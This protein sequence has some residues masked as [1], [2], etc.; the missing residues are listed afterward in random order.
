MRIA[1]L[2]ANFATAGKVLV[3][4]L[5][6]AWVN[7][8][9]LVA[10]LVSDLVAKLLTNLVGDGRTTQVDAGFVAAAISMA[11]DDGGPDVAFQDV[12]RQRVANAVLVL[13]CAQVIGN[14]N[15]DIRVDLRLLDI[16]AADRAAGLAIRASLDAADL[17]LVLQRIAILLVELH[18]AV[19]AAAAI[20]ATRAAELHASRPVGLGYADKQGRRCHSGGQ[21]DANDNRPLK[22]AFHG[23]VL[24]DLDL[25]RYFGLK[26][27]SGIG[28]A[29]LSGAK[30]GKMLLADWQFPSASLVTAF[31]A[32]GMV[33]MGTRL[34]YR[35][36]VVGPERLPF[37]ME[38]CSPTRFTLPMPCL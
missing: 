36:R 10:D 16:E 21:G 28:A 33:A 7:L 20:A 3:D 22:V 23:K 19:G 11:R 9:D 37:R 2:V 29:F 15:A 4:V 18:A 25:R 13:V 35:P 32:E 38:V 14:A 1:N 17:G 5:A 26:W 31:P 27:G 8:A 30:A 12:L 6:E 24:L 34:S